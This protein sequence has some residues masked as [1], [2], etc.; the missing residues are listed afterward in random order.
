MDIHLRGGQPSSQYSTEF[1]Q[2]MVSRTL[3][4]YPKYGHVADSIAKGMDCMSSARDRMREYTRTGNTEFLMDACNY[5]MFEWMY[6]SHPDAHFTPQD[7]D[8]SPGRIMTD[9]TRHSKHADQMEGDL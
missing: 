8:S 5:L 4:S 2:G 9:G 1:L 3:M 6:P 7:S